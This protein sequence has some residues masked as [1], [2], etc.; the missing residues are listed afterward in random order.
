M[1]MLASL[2]HMKHNGAGLAG[3]TVF[4][5]GAGYEI[6]I[7]FAGE[8]TIGRVG[9]DGKTVKIFL[10]F[11]AIRRGPPF[12]EGAMQILGNGA[13]NLRNINPLIVLGVEKMRGELLPATALVAFC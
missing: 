1:T 10:A 13:G 11:R 6:K 2:L 7:L 5:F 4:F 8:R 3:Q 12:L 9:I